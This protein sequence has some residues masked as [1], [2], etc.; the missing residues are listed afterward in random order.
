MA[1]FVRG[2]SSK[3]FR[4]LKNESKDFSIFGFIF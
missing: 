1:L 2:Q 3:A 4:D